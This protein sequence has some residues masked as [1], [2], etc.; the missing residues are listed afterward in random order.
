M[1]IV[2]I[3]A[4]NE[5]AALGKLLADMPPCVRVHEVRPIVLNDGSTDATVDVAI[6]AGVE[7]LDRAENRGKGAILKAGLDSLVDESYDVLVMMDADGQHDPACLEAMVTPILKG[8]VDVVVG[9]RYIDGGGRGNTPWN[10]YLVRFSVR[11]ALRM[12]L[13][14]TVTDPFSGYRALSPRAVA[15]VGLRGERY[16]SELEMLFC[17]TSNALRMREV[18]IPRIYRPGMSK[19]G[20]RYG[21][22]LGRIDV[23]SR[24][25]ITIAREALRSRSRPPSHPTA[26]RLHDRVS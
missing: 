26:R 5:E 24:Y 3:P 15:C 6:S 22:M 8:S 4:Y 13:D 20:A 9:S 11:T 2:L 23:V 18:P 7:V 19:M 14:T 25:A 21:P 1:I 16:E 10:R 17:T 12:L